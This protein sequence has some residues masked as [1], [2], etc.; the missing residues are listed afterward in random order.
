MRNDYSSV[1]A[2]VLT[3]F[4]LAALAAVSATA[5]DDPDAAI[6]GDEDT[7]SW[8]GNLNDAIAEAK[9]TKRPIF[10]EFRCAP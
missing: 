10:L 2:R 6:A 3:S 1:I 4:S 9:L 5:Q 8:H 7:L